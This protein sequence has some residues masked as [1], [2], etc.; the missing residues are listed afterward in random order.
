[1]KDRVDYKTGLLRLL[2]SKA[3]PSGSPV[4]PPTPICLFESSSALLKSFSSNVCVALSVAGQ[5][6]SYVGIAWNVIYKSQTPAVARGQKEWALSQ[7]D[8]TIVMELCSAVVVEWSLGDVRL[9]RP[10]PPEA[11]P[12]PESRL[13]C[14]GSPASPTLS[15]MARRTG[16]G[17]R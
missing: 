8:F 14:A 3:P 15:C 13:R 5:R 1:M 9:P 7:C 11:A 16:T 12:A 4:W 17:S 6:Q 10:K 2:G